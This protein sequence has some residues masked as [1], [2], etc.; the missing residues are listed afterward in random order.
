MARIL[1][2]SQLFIVALWPPSAVAAHDPLSAGVYDKKT[3][4][5]LQ[6]VCT[7]WEVGEK[8]KVCTAVQFV[9][10]TQ[11]Q[12]SNIG[13]LFEQSDRDHLISPDGAPYQAV[14]TKNPVVPNGNEYDGPFQITHSLWETECGIMLGLPIS[15]GSLTVVGLSVGIPIL[16]KKLGPKPEAL[17]SAAPEA[18]D[19]YRERKIKMLSKYSGG[20]VGGSVAI[21]M[22]PTI[23]DVFRDIYVY[24]A[25]ELAKKRVARRNHQITKEWNAAWFILVGSNQNTA[26]A[27]RSDIFLAMVK[28]I[29]KTAAKDW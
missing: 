15:A 21:L 14:Q 17:E 9:L 13:E 4:D 24:P 6:A 2:I 3:G 12:V 11:K 18:W 23:A 26:V 10:T 22:V 16:E 19:E 20:I 27:V 1:F 8:S 7:A 25:Y 5:S 29:Q 28:T